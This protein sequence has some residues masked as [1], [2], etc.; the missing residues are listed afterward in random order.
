[1]SRLT[2]AALSAPEVELPGDL[3]YT[4]RPSTKSVMAEGQ[5]IDG[6][7]DALAE[8]DVDGVVGIYCELLD[9]R[10][11]PTVKG[12][13]RASVVMRR[14]WDRDEVTLPQIEHLL[15]GVGAA[16]RPT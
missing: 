16:D 13:H 9:L 10:L 1:M 7:L 2:L 5:A 4:V 8:D 6:R 12:Q 11:I 14:L 3:V 15:K